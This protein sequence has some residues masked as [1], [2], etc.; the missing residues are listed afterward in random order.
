MP[1]TLRNIYNKELSFENL[2]KA[3]KK[4]RCGKRTKKKVILFELL[5]EQELLR[6][7]KELENCTYKH[8]GYIKFKIHQNKERI[9]MS[10]E[11]MD[12]VVHQWYVQ[13]FIITDPHGLLSKQKFLFSTHSISFL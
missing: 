2:L 5:L 6:L 4:A 8:S 11:Y 9:I 13:H 10:S 1:K 12:R 3:H 7:E